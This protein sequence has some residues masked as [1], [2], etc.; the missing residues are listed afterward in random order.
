MTNDVAE[1]I[2]AFLKLREA[3]LWD[4]KCVYEQRYGKS[5]WEYLAAWSA[6]HNILQDLN[7]KSL[8]P[9]ER[10]ALGLEHGLS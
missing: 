10:E 7:I 1:G 5:N 3:E 6:V 4:K 8:E 9:Y 2:E